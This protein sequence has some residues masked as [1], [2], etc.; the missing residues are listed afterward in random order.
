MPGWTRTENR[1]IRAT[2]EGNHRLRGFRAHEQLSSGDGRERRFLSMGNSVSAAVREKILD[3][4]FPARCPVCGRILAPDERLVCRKCR[5]ELPWVREPVCQRCGKPISDPEKAYCADC[6]RSDHMY[7][8]GRSALLYEKGIRLSVNRMKFYNHREYLPFYAACIWK[9]GRSCLCS[10]QVRCIIPI[11]MHPKKR[12]ERGFDQTVLLARELSGL[13]GIPVLEDMLIRVRYTKASRKLGREHRQ[14]NLRGAFRVRKGAKIPE[15]VL[16]L[17]DIY[18]TG[19]TMDYAAGALRSAGVK[20]IFF[21]TLC[22]GR[23]V[24]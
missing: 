23:G 7:T 6:S 12:A 1:R 15:P 3:L 9:A 11:P 19:T 17:D 16:L 18:T 14:K 24:E 8:E 20:D 4:L 5:K 13:C 10:W 22:T 2:S 21:L